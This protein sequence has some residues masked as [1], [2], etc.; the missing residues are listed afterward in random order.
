[1]KLYFSPAACSLAPHIVLR[2]LGATF[3]AEKVDLGTKKTASGGDFTAVSPL[4][5]VPAMT[6]DNGQTLTE[7][8]V[9]VQYLADQKPDAGLAPKNG[10]MERVRLQE[11]LNFIS[12]ELH[13]GIGQLFNPKM[14]DEYKA[15]VKDKLQSRFAH[16]E[17]HFAKQPYLLGANYSVADA[18][19]FTILN[20]TNFTK[21]P[22]DAYPNVQAYMGRVASRPKVQEALKAE[23]LV[24]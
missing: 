2:E 12:A 10:T 8:S 17:K 21:V 14:P 5:Y 22:L 4:G 13:K 9:I 6:L 11:W 7:A 3:D 16:L 1:M 20:W 23:G 24:K 19:A 18:Y 15:V